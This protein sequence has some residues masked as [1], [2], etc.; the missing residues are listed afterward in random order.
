MVQKRDSLKMAGA[1][2]VWLVGHTLIPVAA[3]WLAIRI[4]VRVLR[5][6]FRRVLPFGFAGLHLLVVGL[7]TRIARLSPKRREAAEANARFALVSHV[8]PPEWSGQ[9][10]VIGRLLEGLDASQYCLVSLKDY[11][12][13]P[14]NFVARLP[15]KYYNLPP[16]WQV[17][18]LADRAT[19]TWVN[20]F[21][22]ALVR[23]FRIA[24][25]LVG[26]GC[27]TVISASGNL[28]DL[29][30]AY[31]AACITGARFVPYLFDDF[32]YQWPLNAGRKEARLI[33]KI[34]F[35]KANA[36]IVPNEFLK[37]EIE[38]RHPGADV[39]VVRNPTERP[40]TVAVRPGRGDRSR[41]ATRII[42]YTGA[43]YHVN[44][45]A[46]RNLVAAIELDGVPPTEIHLYT[47]QSSEWL[48][49]QGIKGSRVVMRGHVPPEYVR[50]IQ[51]QADVLFLGFAFDSAIPELV[52]TSAPGKL[53]D[54]LATG[55][56]ILAHVPADS[57]VAWY[58]TEH[59]CGMVVSEDGPDALSRGIKMI[60]TDPTLRRYLQKNAQER[61][62]KDFDPREAQAA[63]LSA[64]RWGN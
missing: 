33:E 10:V 35:H 14:G 56:P 2:L 57:F 58:L 18:F 37:R 8:L 59:K 45:S 31:V 38:G 15:G 48:E 44:L 12:T 52:A 24:R 23:G 6:M 43:I 42:T 27:R 5:F 51:Q 22:G 4:P 32:T 46:F 50:K 39:R 16:E 9:A 17:R 7:L 55:V 62:R 19:A 30:A 63:F 34:I 54:Y 61:A 64:I 20:L 41:D 29:P 53:G 25:L 28:V 11:S 36:I 1:I 60:L 49:E 47:A 21:A 3:V 40:T 26:S 13:F